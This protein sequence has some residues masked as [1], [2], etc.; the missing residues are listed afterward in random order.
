MRPGWNVDGKAG[1]ISVQGD[2]LV[3]SRLGGFEAE[4]STFFLY[5]LWALVE[6]EMQPEGVL[7]PQGGHCWSVCSSFKGD[8]C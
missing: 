6:I 5:R 3:V 7:G 4:N 8:P 2:Q 1:Q